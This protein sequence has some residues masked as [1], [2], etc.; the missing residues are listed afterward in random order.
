MDGDGLFPHYTTATF[1]TTYDSE[2]S[3]TTSDDFRAS[4]IFRTIDCVIFNITRRRCDSSIFIRNSR[5]KRNM[6]NFSV[7]FR[8]RRFSER[9]VK[10]F[11]RASIA[12]LCSSA[13]NSQAEIMREFMLVFS[14]A[15]E[16]LRECDERRA[17]RNR[18]LSFRFCE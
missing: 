8:D 14:A 15:T 18:K 2:N 4:S 17:A 6:Q 10:H 13:L 5:S 3:L 1:F 11:F 9:N 16:K 12:L 7:A